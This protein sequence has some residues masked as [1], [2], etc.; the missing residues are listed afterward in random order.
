MMDLIE[1][2]PKMD[3]A[4]Q[5]IEHLV[6]ELRVYH[7]I[8]SPLFQRREQREAAHSYLQGVLATLP[9]TSIEPMVL[10]VDG[11]APDVGTHFGRCFTCVGPLS[12][13]SDRIRHD[14]YNRLE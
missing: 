2:T 9:R 11:V 4:I 14:V 6:E 12:A 13:P 7:A 10:A 8:Y 5:D 3:L 1:T